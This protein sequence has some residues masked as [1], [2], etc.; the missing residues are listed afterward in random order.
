MGPSSRSYTLLVQ[1]VLSRSFHG[2][3]AVRGRVTY[4]RISDAELLM[5]L[6]SRINVPMRAMRPK[7]R[8]LL[9][10]FNTA[11]LGGSCA[12]AAFQLRPPLGS[13]MLTSPGGY[14]HH[15]RQNIISG[16][17][18]CLAAGYR[19]VA[20]R[21]RGRVSLRCWRLGYGRKAQGDKGS[22]RG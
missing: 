21:R 2:K 15:L 17:S 20:G 10:I 11:R 19:G 8:F 16:Q 13:N 7:K 12:F 6:H 1:Q 9:T 5:P 4:L 14:R 18:R 22:P 3:L